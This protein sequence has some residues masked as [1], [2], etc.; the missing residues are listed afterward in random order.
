MNRIIAKIAKLSINAAT[1]VLVER[2]VEQ[3]YEQ[4]KADQARDIRDEMR[5][6]KQHKAAN[7]IEANWAL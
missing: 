7:F 4:G 2:L 3:A 5:Q 6:D 1:R